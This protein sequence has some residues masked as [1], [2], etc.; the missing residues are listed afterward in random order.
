M[1]E[2]MTAESVAEQLAVTV[3][4][5]AKWRH[6]GTGPRYIKLGGNGRCNAVRYRRSDIEEWIDAQAVSTRWLEEHAVRHDR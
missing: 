6:F 4:T 1:H 3:K 2:L 5:L